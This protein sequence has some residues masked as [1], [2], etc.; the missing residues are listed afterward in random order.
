[1]FSFMV[2]VSSRER[3]CCHTPIS[4]VT[5]G[6]RANPAV[7]VRDD[8]E[9]ESRGGKA[10]WRRFELDLFQVTHGISSVDTTFVQV[11]I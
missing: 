7:P 9:F 8:E 2:D 3:K 4:R 5:E 10:A 1:M 11:K 6:S